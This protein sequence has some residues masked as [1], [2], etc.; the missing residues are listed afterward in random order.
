L[1]ETA[2]ALTHV[3]TPIKLG[4][5]EVRNRVVRTAHGTRL[6]LYSFDELAAFHAARA[7]GGVGLTILEILGVHPTSPA[8]LRVFDPAHDEGYRR[9][10]PKLKPLGMKVFQQLWHGGHHVMPVDGSPCWS[11]SDI[12]SPSVGTVPVSMTKMMIDEIV[13]AFGK[14]AK[15]C[16][17]WGLDGIELHAA[18][19]YLPQQ[20]LST[21]TN[22]REDDYGGSFENRARFTLEILAAIRSMVSKSMAVSVRVGADDTPD[23]VAGG[24]TVEDNIRLVKMIQ[25]RGLADVINISLG[26]YYAFDKML[27]GMYYGA[28]YELPTSVPVSRSTKLP[29]IVIGRIRTLEEADQIIRAGDADMVAMTRAHIADPD[30]VRKT[31]AGHPEQVR[32]CIGCNQGCLAGVLGPNARLGCTVNPAVS[33]EGS[34][35]EDTWPAADKARKVLVVG[36]GPAGMEA[37]RVA[38]LRGHDVTLVEA[39]NALGGTV[40]IAAKVPNRHGIRDIT[41]WLEQEIYRLGVKVQLST[42]MDADDVLG[43]GADK[44]ILA[45]GSTPRMDGVQ[46][47]NPADP[48]S[49][50]EQP[51]VLSSHDLLTGARDP[52]RHAVVIDDVGHYEGIAAVEYLLNKGVSVT[53][54]TR[55]G[56][57]APMLETA[58][59][60]EPFLRRNWSDQLKMEFR[61]RAVAITPKE[62]SYGPT[63][64][65]KTTNHLRT[66]AADTVVFVSQNR[67][68]REMF[69]AL[70]ARGVDVKVVGDA[71]S[72]RF[73]PV[74][75]KEARLA[76][77][78]A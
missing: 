44:V 23:G 42:Y 27:A 70:K 36:G 63:Y 72:P 15:K 5:V 47:N 41:V 34:L 13:E 22:R 14:A 68:N 31:A 58:A 66:V 9:M 20:F 77:V 50:M 38:R 51:H 76:G 12:P 54:L 73:L 35:A 29:T 16:E 57:L 59:T 28:G 37:A 46:T 11:A 4:P 25:D 17:D 40:N 3:L 30:I 49:G 32:P 26:G 55:H 56:A 78:A 10:M 74:A 67:P 24:A 18:H 52:G 61:V 65:P 39:S 62:V 48:V 60:P 69:E 1:G 7:R 21:L 45:T 2:V 53:L 6:A 64:L 43:F 33:Y 8:S 75:M 19:S 71:Q